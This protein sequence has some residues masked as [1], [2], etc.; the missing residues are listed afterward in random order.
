MSGF[1]LEHFKRFV[2]TMDKVGRG[3]I[4]GD[5]SSVLI[6]PHNW[7]ELNGKLLVSH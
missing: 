4:R 6:D 7:F 3:M 1:V 5:Y 2:M